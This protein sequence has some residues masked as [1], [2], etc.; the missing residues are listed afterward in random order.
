[1]CTM[2]YQCVML[3]AVQ[4]LINIDICCMI[5]FQ[6]SSL[7]VFHCILTF[8]SHSHSI[9]TSTSANLILMQGSNLIFFTVFIYFLDAENRVFELI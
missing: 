4:Y 2:T 1:M 3:I 9:R 7:S 8:F 6:C 5:L